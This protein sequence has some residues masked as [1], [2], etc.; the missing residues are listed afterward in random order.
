MTRDRCVVGL[1]PPFGT[2]GA[3]AANFVAHAV[4]A[5]QPR[6]LVLITPRETPLPADY[7]ELERNTRLA[8]GHAFYLPGSHDPVTQRPVEDWNKQTPPFIVMMRRSAIPQQ[9]AG[10]PAAEELLRHAW[11]ARPNTAD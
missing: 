10:P 3:L 2:D 5:L 4:A 6:L 9:A 8:D 7:V 1:N 11:R